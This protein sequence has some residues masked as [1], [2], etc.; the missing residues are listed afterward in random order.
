MLYLK[1]AIAAVLG[2]V[3][4]A[5][6]VPRWPLG[7]VYWGVFFVNMLG[8]LVLGVMMQLQQL[9]LY[10]AQSSSWHMAIMVGTLGSLTTFSTFSFDVLKML[11]SGEWTIATIYVVSSV[12]LG[13]F[14][15]WLGTQVGSLIWG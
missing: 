4:R 10:V 11:Q 6:I 14:F 2:A 7:E 8:C 15:C 5:Y 12:L 13:L 1:I 3:T 9:Q